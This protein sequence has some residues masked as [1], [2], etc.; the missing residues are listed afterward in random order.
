M[1]L[2]RFNKSVDREQFE[3]QF[4]KEMERLPL[5]ILP[6]LSPRDFPPKPLAIACR[7]IFMPLDVV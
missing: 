6:L 4:H 1:A 7:R 2:D 5:R 3:R